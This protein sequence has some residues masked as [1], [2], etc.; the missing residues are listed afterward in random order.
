MPTLQNQ[1]RLVQKKVRWRKI[2]H[3]KM[4]K[5]QGPGPTAPATE[6]LT[7]EGLVLG[8]P[9]YMAPEQVEGRPADARTDIFAFGVVLYE[10]VTGRKAFEGK[11]QASLMA[12]I[13]TSH[14]PAITSIQPLTPPALEHLIERCLQKDP[15]ERWQSM[16][17]LEGELKWIAEEATP[18]RKSKLEFDKPLAKRAPSRALRSRLFI[19]A[20]LLLLLIGGAVWYRINRQYTLSRFLSTV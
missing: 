8:T 19:G 12:A 13:L 11:S 9:E 7:E 18:A 20:G 16:R 15:E 2:R 6:S 3:V 17:D 5:L 1:K 14:P 10:M 4:A